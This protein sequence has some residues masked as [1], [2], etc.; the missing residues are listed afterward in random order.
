MSTS[1]SDFNKTWLYEMPEGVGKFETYDMLS[2]NLNS[3]KKSILSTAIKDLGN[4]LKKIDLQHSAYY[5]IEF[6][7]IIIIGCELEKKPYGLVVLLT[8]KNPEYRGKPPFASDLY[9]L[10]LKD[11]PYN[12][13][14]LSDVTL[15]DEGN[16]IWKRLFN[17]G[18]KILIYDRSNPGQDFIVCN[19]L[20]EFESY[21]KHDDRTY[22]NYQYVLSENEE[23][24]LE[25]KFNFRMRKHREDNDLG[26][27]DPGEEGW[28]E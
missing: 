15:S 26:I 9:N 17:K 11:S 5:W 28:N 13:R 18:H 12:I 16:N 22:Q 4:N 21:F 2:Y 7:D 20:A 24:L 19:D 10:I 23:K 1:R 14:L 25:T 27:F 3:I 6:N 8:G